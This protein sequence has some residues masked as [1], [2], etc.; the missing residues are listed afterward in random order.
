MSAATQFPQTF[1][2]KAGEITDRPRIGD[3]AVSLAPD[4]KTVLEETPVTAQFLREHRQR[5]NAMNTGDPYYHQ[6]RSG[7]RAAQYYGRP[8][9]DEQR[10][11]RKAEQNR[12]LGDFDATMQTAVDAGYR[13][14]GDRTERLASRNLS[15]RS[16]Q[17]VLNE[18]RRLAAATD[19]SQVTEKPEGIDQRDF[20]RQEVIRDGR[21]V[22][23]GAADR[24]AASRAT[25][26][27]ARKNINENRVAAAKQR[28]QDD[29][30][31][32][33]QTMDRIQSATPSTPNVIRDKNGNVIGYSYR[34]QKTPQGATKEQVAATRKAEADTARA[35]KI[36]G[37]AA[38]DAVAIGSRTNADERFDAQY[39]TKQAQL[40]G[41]SYQDRIAKQKE[42]DGKMAA[43]AD[44]DSRKAIGQGR[45]ASRE[46]E[47]TNANKTPI[48]ADTPT[49]AQG[50]NT[51][52]PG[53]LLKT[54]SAGAHNRGIATHRLDISTPAGQSFATGIA[55]TT[56][57][58]P[59]AT[60]KKDIPT[61]VD[62]VTKKPITFQTVSQ[63][64]NETREHTKE[65]MSHIRSVQ[66]NV[67]EAKNS[68]GFNKS[69]FEGRL[70][71]RLSNAPPAF[72]PEETRRKNQQK[73]D[74]LAGK[75]PLTTSS[76]DPSWRPPTPKGKEVREVR[77][78]RMTPG[79]RPI[80]DRP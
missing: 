50:M 2:N 74:L 34:G 58:V 33:K 43:F 22:Q 77:T 32:P 76:V 59:A 20:D 44:P 42:F 51:P 11:A 16:R 79:G 73:D 17:D 5:G 27:E 56:P 39:G 9:L 31:K 1:R 62:R 78:G 13:P 12:M 45:V 19:A 24:E 7:G 36:D 52:P 66:H 75:L 14:L 63:T 72:N 69:V 46:A 15:D 35:T 67:K 71:E 47:K 30:T 68:S 38:K 53:S 54:R 25:R 64:P 40:G 61:T 18:N 21:L 28:V 48:G 49:L 6:R 8:H 55:G 29:A 80:P 3:T 70:Q 4:G 60:V 37:V 10:A 41:G 26:E 23:R 57:M 65:Y